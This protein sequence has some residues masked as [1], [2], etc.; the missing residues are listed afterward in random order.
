M[1]LDGL[2][3]WS[4]FLL[5]LPRVQGKQ[6][7]L[8]FHLHSPSL[9]AK[10]RVVRFGSHTWFARVGALLALIACPLLGQ[11]SQ[12]SQ[13]RTANPGEI[14]PIQQGTCRIRPQFL[15]PEFM[16]AD[17][18]RDPREYPEFLDKK[19][20]P[21]EFIKPSF[22][23]ADMVKPQMLP[24]VYGGCSAYHF[25]PAQF[26][27]TLEPA[28]ATTRKNPALM[29][30]A[31]YKTA[32]AYQYTPPAPKEDCCGGDVKAPAAT[33]APAKPKIN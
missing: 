29:Q 12:N 18:G 5:I 9:P 16:H 21:P 14:Q 17:F 33:P 22:V 7:A 23:K 24:R 13:I 20:Y 8:I 28:L 10:V 15:Q 1:R 27:Y 2:S 25:K 6:I 31:E 32:A 26:G 30:V 3:V 11:N 19:L 4:P